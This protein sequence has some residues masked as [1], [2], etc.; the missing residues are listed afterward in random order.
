MTEA[1]GLDAVLRARELRADRQRL[2]LAGTGRPVLS[3]TVVAPGPIKNSPR[4]ERVFGAAATAVTE[5][6][7]G[8]GWPVVARTESHGPTGPELQSAVAARP[9]DLKRALVALEEAHP[10]GRLWDLDVVTEAGPFSRVEV[11]VPAR[12]CLVC[13]ADGAGCA[14][15]GRH[16]A[17]EVADAV[18][19]IVRTPDPVRAGVRRPSRPAEVGALAAEAL[20]VEVRLA[21]KPGLVDVLDDGAHPD[22]TLSHFLAAADAL[23][24]WFARMAELGGR[25]GWRVAQLRELGVEAERDML[26]AT[27]GV[28]TH[29]GAI[30]VLGWLCALAGG[31]PSAGEPEGRVGAWDSRARE[32]ARPFVHELRDATGAP[33]HGRRAFARHGLLGARGEAASGF[34]SVTRRALPCYRAARRRGWAEDDALLATLVALIG[35]VGDTNL[36]ARAGLP[37]LRAA[38]E[39]ASVLSVRDLA[40]DEL[41]AELVAANSWFSESGWSPG[42]SADLLAATWLVDRLQLSRRARPGEPVPF[43]GV[44]PAAVG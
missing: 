15:A 36:V 42:G 34:G 33:S 8:A 12:R 17:A 35:G 44:R 6:L 19:R 40:P 4:I 23:E 2:L 29:R 27:G 37:A 9:T 7:A 20:R 11:G 28:N 38:Q 10:W 30:F 22:M 21:P 32:L 39:W 26:A 24:P 25:P 5:A 16:P 3:L 1:V 31:A 43:T 13:A 14:R 41:R 18:D